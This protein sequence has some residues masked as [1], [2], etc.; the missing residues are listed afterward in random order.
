ML[1][2]LWQNTR[3]AKRYHTKDFTISEFTNLNQVN[4]TLDE[5]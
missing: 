1:K 2:K 3:C 5:I 4:I